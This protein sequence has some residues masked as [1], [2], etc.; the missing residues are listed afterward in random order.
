M[1]PHSGALDYRRF[2]LAAAAML[3]S[4][5]EDESSA[6]AGKRGLSSTEVKQTAHRLAGVINDIREGERDGA[7]NEAP[8]RLAPQPTAPRENPPAHEP[9]S[10]AAGNAR[11]PR[12]TAVVQCRDPSQK[13][14]IYSADYSRFERAAAAAMGEEPGS[15][16]SDDELADDGIFSKRTHKALQELEDRLAEVQAEVEW[17]R[18][19][20]GEE[21]SEEERRSMFRQMARNNG[22]STPCC[23]DALD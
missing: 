14:S 9:P 22:H 2:D 3:G 4:D 12:S 18:E 17:E 16:N 1:A 15:D 23:L 10:A 7:A 19:E 5:S 13:K 20:Q 11:S 21:K 8:T 6:T